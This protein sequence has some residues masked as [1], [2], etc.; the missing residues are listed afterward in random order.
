MKGTIPPSAI[1]SFATAII[2]SLMTAAAISSDI[3]YDP[4]VIGT[5]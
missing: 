5:N 2:H 4:S 3:A 1:K